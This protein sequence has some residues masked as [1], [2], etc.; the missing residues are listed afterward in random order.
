LHREKE[1]ERERV[2]VAMMLAKALLEIGGSGKAVTVIDGINDLLRMVLMEVYKYKK[3]YGNNNVKVLN[4][5][6]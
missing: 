4:C 3:S 6:R 2:K 5:K 1:R